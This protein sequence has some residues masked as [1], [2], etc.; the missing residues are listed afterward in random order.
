MNFYRKNGTPVI[1][2]YLKKAST[3]MNFGD[4]VFLNGGYVDKAGATTA[5][6]DIIGVVQETIASTD[7][8]YASARPIAVEMPDKG[9]N[10][11]WFVALVG[12]GTPV[13]AT[14]VGN[15]Y[16]LTSAGAVD[17]TAS[18]Y[19]VVKVQAI[20]SSTLVIVSFTGAPGTNV[21]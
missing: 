19:K 5:A 16:D 17:L 15:S 4:A 9:E 7:S 1:Q 8:D 18:S 2:G 14:H 12:A 6:K 11:D 13:Q 3:A 20:I 10:G 21:S